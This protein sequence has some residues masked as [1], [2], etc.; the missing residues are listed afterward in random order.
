MNQ[1]LCSRLTSIVSVNLTA[2]L[3]ILIL[4]I[5]NWHL[6]RWKN[7]PKGNKWLEQRFQ[8]PFLASANPLPTNLWSCCGVCGSECCDEASITLCPWVTLMNR[9]FLGSLYRTYEKDIF[10]GLSL[11]DLGAVCYCST[12]WPILTDTPCHRAERAALLCVFSESKFVTSRWK[13]PGGGYLKQV[14]TNKRLRN[15]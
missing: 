1:T 4:Q 10:A 14:E 2:H 12:M 6:K 7:L 8:N 9:A 15:I 13:E 5:R 3:I 11:Q